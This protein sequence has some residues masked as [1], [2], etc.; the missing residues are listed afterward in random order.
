MLIDLHAHTKGISRCCK[1]Y[2]TEVLLAA[3]EAGLDGICLCNHYQDRYVED[4][5]ALG[6]AR[7]YNDEFRAVRV[8]GEELGVRVLYGIEV[9]MNSP[10]NHH[11]LVYGVDESFLLEHPNLYE[12]TQA[13]LH[14][15]VQCGMYLPDTIT[16]GV[17]LGQYLK[18]ADT[19]KLRVQEIGEMTAYDM[20]Y[21]KY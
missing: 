10:L 7:R 17:Q 21:S 12:V 5:D 9:T 14:K 18:T 6:F 11:M 2:G 16:D 8:V 15:W 4:G 20:Q 3:K 1:A 19:V 13:E